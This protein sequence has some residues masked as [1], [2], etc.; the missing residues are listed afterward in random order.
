MQT[1]RS[2]PPSTIIPEVPYADVREAAAWLCKAFG[3]TE[4]LRIANHRVQLTI[5]DGAIVVIEGSRP[6]QDDPRCGHAIMVRVEALDQHF[7]RA[8][9]FGVRVLRPPATYPYGERQYTVEDPGGHVRTFS[10]SVADVHPQ[11]WGGELM[12]EESADARGLPRL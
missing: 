2:I 1:N 12:P 8:Q 11:E 5:G 4:R 6:V 9:Q 10:E 3:F 7:Q